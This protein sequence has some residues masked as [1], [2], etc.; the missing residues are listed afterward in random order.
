MHRCRYHGAEF[1]D[2][3]FFHSDGKR[4][5][6]REAVRLG[7]ARYERTKKAAVRFK[8]YE[9]TEGGR[10]RKFKYDL[11]EAGRARFTRYQLSEKGAA[12]G[13]RRRLRGEG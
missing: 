11:T 13:F 2:E 7:N 10:A 9:Q 1:P 4:W 5:R 6:C 12:R 8:R 3:H